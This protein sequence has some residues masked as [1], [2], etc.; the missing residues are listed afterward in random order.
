MTLYVLV[1]ED[2]EGSMSCLA[3]GILNSLGF[4][5]ALGMEDQVVE[6]FR[7]PPS[8]EWASD[9]AVLPVV[10]VA[11]LPILQLAEDVAALVVP[12]FLVRIDLVRILL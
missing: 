4:P 2:A 8:T 11:D 10:A 1:E 3:H 12:A 9:P 5:N 7:N 6:V